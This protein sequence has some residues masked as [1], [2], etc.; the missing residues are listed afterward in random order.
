MEISAALK[1]SLAGRYASALFD[2]ASEAG[3][4]TAVETD[5]DKIEGALEQSPEFAALTTNPK[6]SRKQAGVALR[7]LG[8]LLGISDL[9]QNF[10]GTLAE[11]R[12]L[13]KLP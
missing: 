2:L 13:S 8:P 5:L 1:A 7:N 3:I 10:L 11:N 4:V 9:T 6:V 12:R